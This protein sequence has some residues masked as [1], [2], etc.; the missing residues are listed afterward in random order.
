MLK[1]SLT[2]SWSFFKNHVVA[3]SLIILPIVVPIDVLTGLYQHFLAGEKYVFSEQII[4][5]IIGFVAYPIYAVGVVFYIASVIT[6]E[7]ID[8][9][10]SWRLGAKFWL[11][12]TI[13]SILVGLATTLG[14]IILVIPGFIIVIRY[15]FSEFDLLLNNSKPLDA[16]KNSWVATRQYM[17]VMLG[18]Y[19]VITLV[20]YVPCYL[21]ASLFDKSSISYWLLD[22]ALNIAYSVLGTLYTIFAFR[23]YEFAKLQHNQSLNQDA[24]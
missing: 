13:M 10:T 16:T 1:L 3:L 24:P 17:W 14:F 12:Y 5:L 11:P 9:R 8:A 2:D 6:G 22:T 19:G 20:L 4:P 18:G 23:M 7:S 21:I 15:A